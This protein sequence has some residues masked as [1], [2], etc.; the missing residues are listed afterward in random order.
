MQSASFA[1][2]TSP[3]LLPCYAC[4]WFVYVGGYLFIYLGPILKPNE[5][6]KP[7]GA[8]YNLPLA[9]LYSLLYV[10]CF[11]FT[12]GL[13]S[14]HYLACRFSPILPRGPNKS[15][16]TVP[17]LFVNL[18]LTEQMIPCPTFPKIVI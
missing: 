16:T 5:M 4:P 1:R 12:S 9:N 6:L 15:Q 10:F 2:V 14:I 17:S 8:D 13:F 3:A 7:N 18:D 11:S